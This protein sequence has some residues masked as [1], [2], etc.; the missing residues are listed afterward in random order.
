VTIPPDSLAAAEGS[1]GTFARWLEGLLEALGLARATI[2]A[3]PVLADAVR[4]FAASH[5]AHVVRCIVLGA[6]ELD[7]SP[8][9]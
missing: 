2:V 5:P 3:E 4:R 1:E 6:D 7:A 9:G 8:I